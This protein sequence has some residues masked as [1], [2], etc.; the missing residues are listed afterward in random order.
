MLRDRFCSAVVF[1]VTMTMLPL[2]EAAPLVS[3][4]WANIA[5]V[6]LQGQGGRSY[7]GYLGIPY[8][9]PPLGR[10]RFL[11]AQPPPSPSNN[12]FNA[13]RPPA[14]CTQPSA[15]LKVGQGM[16]EDCLYLNVFVP[17]RNS[18]G[19]LPVLVWLH[20]GVFM[21][22]GANRFTPSKLVADQD[23]IVVVVQF[24]L[25]VFG[26]LSSASA[27]LP[28][29]LGLWD[30]NLALKWV[31]DNI[32]AFGGDA[33]RVT[34]SGQSSGSISV[35]LHALSPYS[36]DLFRR[37][38]MQSGG[39][40][41]PL[42]I[43]ETPRPFFLD[44]SREVGCRSEDS[45]FSRYS[46][47]HDKDVVDCLRSKSTEELLQAGVTS[48]PTATFEFCWVPVV[49][50]NFIPRDPRDLLGDEEYLLSQ[51]ISSTPISFVGVVFVILCLFVCLLKKECF[52]APFVLVFQD[53]DKQLPLTSMFL[54]L[55]CIFYVFIY[56]Q[57]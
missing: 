46:V 35:A 1:V 23:V 28:G 38:V 19:S 2:S 39:P 5:G 50:G 16:S 33:D 12:F 54:C 45:L 7:S 34:L 8:A 17:A 44:L 29:N 37:A 10:L 18:P 14:V 27:A 36:K 40:T 20:G 21:Y 43:N 41:A 51:G 13:S 57:F 48:L 52:H 25:G 9:L 47:T 15:T 53:R 55:F 3:T 22:N 24:R 49:D 32:G 30:Q 6:D 4:Q 26:F 56:F 31:K 42:A 11:K